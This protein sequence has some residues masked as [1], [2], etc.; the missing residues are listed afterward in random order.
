MKRFVLFSFLVLAMGG[1]SL[2][3]IDREQVRKLVD[4]YKNAALK[5]KV[6]I[7]YWSVFG[8]QESSKEETKYE[9]MGTVIDK[10]GTIV[11]SAFAVDPSKLFQRL[12]S[13]E[14]GYQMKS[15]LKEIKII[16]PDNKEVEG[17]IV[18]RD[19][20][21]DLVFLRPKSPPQDGQFNSV[22]LDNSTEPQI[23]DEVI[24]IQRMDED[25]DRTIFVALSRIGGIITKPRLYYLSMDMLEPG[26]PVFSLDGKLVG[27]NTVR[28][29]ETEG[30]SYRFFSTAT[31]S[32]V[33]SVILPAKTIK[34]SA[35]QIKE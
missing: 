11:T 25:V 26:T 12:F 33:S 29:T 27:L 28:V 13:E 3:Q 18:L 4:T 9:V 16:L 22:D 32:P 19:D 5:V 8:G 20:K 7:T 21:L 23:L 31:S 2:A 34:E 17:K 10:N 14:G 15:E 35:A 1:F 30:S 24:S 6:I